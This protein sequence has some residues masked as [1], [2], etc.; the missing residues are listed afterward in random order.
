MIEYEKC[1]LYPRCKAIECDC[2]INSILEYQI[3]ELENKQPKK[4]KKKRIITNKK[5]KK[6]K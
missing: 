3:K 1:G 6:S 4:N 5:V 2:H